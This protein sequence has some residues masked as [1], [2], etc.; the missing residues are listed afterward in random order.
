MPEMGCTQEIV[1][2]SKKDKERY[3]FYKYAKDSGIIVPGLRQNFVP[4]GIACWEEQNRFFISGYFMPQ[5]GGWTSALLAVDGKTGNLVGEYRLIGEGGGECGGHFSGV[6]IS[7]TDLYVT[8]DRC[9]YRVPLTAFLGVSNSCSVAVA[10]T[11]SLEVVPG[12]CN[13][14]VGT[15]WV[16]EHFRS[17]NH[18][19]RV[20]STAA[21]VDGGWMIGYK[22]C[23]DGTLEPD[24][25]FVVPDKIQ[26]I[27]VLDDGRVVLSQ[28]YGRKTPSQ[29][30]VFQDPRQHDSDGFVSVAGRT[31]PLWQLKKRG[32]AQM[33]SAPPM[34]EGCCTMGEEVYVVFESAAYYYRA[35]SPGN[36]AVDPTDKIWRFLP[37]K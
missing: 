29:I 8:G 15:L 13:Y 31:V 6:A 12:S 4:Q 14:S 26:G 34:A 9:L 3:S 18:P 20:G 22:I 1:C 5:A 33:L 27:T 23:S 24:C 21:G 25:V 19:R 7:N 17:G 37:P 2:R 32:E 11:I 35:Y 36:T 30:F 28:S 10:Q 16:C